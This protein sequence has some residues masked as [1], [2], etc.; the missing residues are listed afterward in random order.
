MSEG[1]TSAARKGITGVAF[2]PLEIDKS[3]IASGTI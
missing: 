3:I 2:I 1:S